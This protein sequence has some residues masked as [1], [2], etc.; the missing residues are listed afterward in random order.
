M[1]TSSRPRGERAQLDPFEALSGDVPPRDQRDLMAHPF[2]SLSK[3][4]RVAPIHYK[5]GDVELQVY[6]VAEHGMATIWDADVLIWAASQ[7]SPPRIAVCRPRASSASHPIN[8]STASAAPRAR[9][10]TSSSR[11]R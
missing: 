6:A 2:F 10:A 5:A 1:K 9:A 7:S 4:R 8:S 11:A 3:S